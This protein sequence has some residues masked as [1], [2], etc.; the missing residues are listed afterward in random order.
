MLCWYAVG[1]YIIPALYLS[2]ARKRRFHYRRKLD[3]SKMLDVQEMLERERLI[4][5]PRRVRLMGYVYVWYPI[6]CSS[7]QCI[8]ISSWSLLFELL[9]VWKRP[10]WQTFEACR[11]Y[12]ASPAWGRNWNYCM[13]LQSRMAIIDR[14]IKVFHTLSTIHCT[15]GKDSRQKR[16]MHMIRSI[17]C[18]NKRYKRSFWRTNFTLLVFWC[19]VAAC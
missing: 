5:G 9:L 12:P 16:R 15:C 4:P 11:K 13:L 3:G 14:L 1:Y 19:L 10:L 2:E 6:Q 17:R 8:N 7:S 18:W